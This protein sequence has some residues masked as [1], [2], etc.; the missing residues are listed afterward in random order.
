MDG[1]ERRYNKPGTIHQNSCGWSKAAMK[2][3]LESDIKKIAEGEPIP[4]SPN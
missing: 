3:E 2:N 1:I 4:S